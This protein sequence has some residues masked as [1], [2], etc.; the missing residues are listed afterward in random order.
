MTILQ[1]HQ[2]WAWVVVIANGLVGVWSLAAHRWAALRSRTLWWCILIAEVAIGVQVI[3]GA[4]TMSLADLKA[5]GFHLF[6]GFVALASIGIIYS[7]RSQ[8]R[9]QKYLLYGLG[10]LFL[11]GLCIRAMIL[12]T[13]GAR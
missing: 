9:R 1:I 5:P 2:A 13:P 12:A 3:L 4:A 11:M 10:S 7:Y 6:Y 8:M